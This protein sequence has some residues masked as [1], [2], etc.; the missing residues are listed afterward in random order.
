MRLVIIADG[1]RGLASAEAFK[2]MCF[3]RGWAA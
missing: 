3:G 2:R 1:R